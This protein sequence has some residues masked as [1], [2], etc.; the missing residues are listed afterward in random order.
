MISPASLRLAAVLLAGVA[1]AASA[2]PLPAPWSLERAQSWYGAQ[3]WLI[4][5]NFVPST[6]S[7]QFEMWQAE[8]FDRETIDRELGWAAAIGFNSMRVFLHDMLWADDPGGFFTRVDAYLDIADGHGI[9]TM[10]VLFDSV[11]DPHPRLGP[12]PDP[13][14]GVHNS[15]WVQNPHL[16]LLRDPARHDE[17]EPYV[18]AVVSR[19][20]SDARVLM[21]DLYNEPG[22]RVFPYREH[23]PDNKR[24]LCEALL[25]RVII[26]ARAA[27][28]S[29]PLTAGLWERLGG[30]PDA[31]ESL[32]RL[33]LE[34]SDIL[35]FHSYAPLPRLR[36]TVRWLQGYNRP[37]VCTEYLSRQAK[38]TFSTVLPYFHEQ[39]IGAINWGLVSGRSQTIYPWM[40]WTVPFDREPTLWF[41][42]IFRPDGAPFDPAETA[43]IRA[44]AGSPPR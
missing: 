33:I 27:D 36:T 43:L 11:W 15:R 31:L 16:D 35:T 38:N 28:P 2:D 17:L 18:T 12:Q 10:F 6:A 1:S 34:N 26:W 32:D 7:N 19:Y 40:S 29:Q 41:H 3:P 39:K 30:D 22:N 9:R 21:W 8:T 24:E 4:G 5:A 20:R 14:P 42:D 23:E 37:L 13:I 44:L 25:R